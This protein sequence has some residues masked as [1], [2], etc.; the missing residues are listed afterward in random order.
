[1]ARTI[2]VCSCDHSYTDPAQAPATCSRRGECSLCDC[3]TYQAL[4]AS[5][6]EEK[7]QDIK[8]WKIVRTRPATHVFFGFAAWTDK[9]EPG[10]GS[11]NHA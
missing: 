2:P 9:P 3:E 10:P 6:H 5:E 4:T 1:M 11:D 8:R 7:L